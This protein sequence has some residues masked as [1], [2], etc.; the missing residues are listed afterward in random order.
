MVLG[1]M[2]D[3][4]GVEKKRL[5]SLVVVAWKRKKKSRYGVANWGDAI[6]L[7]VVV[8]QRNTTTTH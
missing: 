5:K 7:G 4:Q 1:R 2:P 3:D 6:E 8:R